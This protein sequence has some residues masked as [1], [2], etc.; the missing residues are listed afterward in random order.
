MAESENVLNL[1]PDKPCRYCKIMPKS[2]P[3]CKNCGCVLHPGYVKYIKNVKII[4]DNQVICCTS[5][6]VGQAD[7]SE[8]RVSIDATNVHSSE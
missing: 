5:S 6:E 3:K 8:L 7:L 2:G 1:L 4:D